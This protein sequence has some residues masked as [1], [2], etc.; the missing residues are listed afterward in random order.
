MDCFLPKHGKFVSSTGVSGELMQHHFVF[1]YPLRLVTNL[2]ADM[3]KKVFVEQSFNK[4][5]SHFLNVVFAL[6]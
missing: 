4:K 5:I 6:I 3:G 2:V 1:T